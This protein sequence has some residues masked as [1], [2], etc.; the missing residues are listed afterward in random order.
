MSGLLNPV[1]QTAHFRLR[2]F[3]CSF[4]QGT[5]KVWP[6]RLITAFFSFV[7]HTL[8]WILSRSDLL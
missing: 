2:E 5:Q 4:R 6:Q 7:P 1:W 8:H 3:N